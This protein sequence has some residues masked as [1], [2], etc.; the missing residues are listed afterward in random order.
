MNTTYATHHKNV[1]IDYTTYMWHMDWR[2]E[3]GKSYPTRRFDRYFMA[4]ENYF[5]YLEKN[6]SQVRVFL[7]QNPAML[8]NAELAAFVLKRDSSL[9]HL[10]GPEIQAR[11]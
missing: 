11:F 10:F 8:H 4:P 3:M 2:D 6:P 5:P 9:L 1:R 7:V